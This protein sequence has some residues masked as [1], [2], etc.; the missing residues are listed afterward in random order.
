MDDNDAFFQQLDSESLLQQHGHSLVADAREILNASP[1][2]RVAGLITTADSPDA[3]A[4]RAMLANATGAPVPAGL[5]VGVVPRQC[6]ADLLSTRVPDHLW[7]EEA[8]QP[9]ATLAVVVATRDGHRFGFF[10]IDAE[11]TGA[12]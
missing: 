4:V 2:T 12:G 9:Q 3:A 1:D 10:P 5:L 11:A 6:V 8:W 7:R